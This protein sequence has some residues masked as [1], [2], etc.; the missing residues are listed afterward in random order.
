MHCARI[1]KAGI[2]LWNIWYFLFWVINMSFLDPDA[3]L[4]QIIAINFYVFYNGFNDSKI[5]KILAPEN[6][7]LLIFHVHI[8]KN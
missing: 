6:S 1:E 5:S 3:A 4:S 7:S 8:C 2:Y